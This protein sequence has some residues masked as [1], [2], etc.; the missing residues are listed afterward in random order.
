MFSLKLSN[1]VNKELG[2]LILSLKKDNLYKTGSV[3]N[4]EKG[5]AF[6]LKA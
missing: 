4:K 5:I 2:D 6:A 1:K 3:V